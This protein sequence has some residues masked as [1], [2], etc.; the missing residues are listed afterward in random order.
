MLCL[1]TIAGTASLCAQQNTDEIHRRFAERLVT[2]YEQGQVA[3]MPIDDFMRS[4]KIIF[5]EGGF[6]NLKRLCADTAASMELFLA[7]GKRYLLRFRND[8]T[9][10]VALSY[11]ADYR[12]VFGVTMLEA[13]EMIEENIRLSLPP[14]KEEYD[15]PVELLK[16]LETGAI[17]LL[18]GN[19]YLIPELNNNRYYVRDEDGKFRLLYSED[20]PCETMAN[21]VTGTEI[22]TELQL[23]ITLIKYGYRTQ[24]FTVP[25]RQWVSYFISEGCTPYFGVMSQEKGKILCEV[26]MHNEMLGYAHIAK[27]QFN[28]TNIK[29][30]HGEITARMNSYIPLSNVKNIFKDAE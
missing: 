22:E 13:E 3:E 8:R 25:L 23:T 18:K 29:E 21:L 6:D 4:E 26:V 1:L 30:G 2:Y 9:D 19:E 27:F 11:P 20:F 7:D 12:L 17:Y 14:E 24:T 5:L 15:I 16:P 10:S 28:P